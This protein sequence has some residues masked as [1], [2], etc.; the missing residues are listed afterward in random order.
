MKKYSTE[1][2]IVILVILFIT[3]SILLIKRIILLNNTYD[4]SADK[5]TFIR[6]TENKELSEKALFE[7]NHEKYF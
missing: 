4:Y 5:L 1:I 6:E 7:T 3:L 2:M